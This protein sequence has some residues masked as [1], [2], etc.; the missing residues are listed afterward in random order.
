MSSAMS[1]EVVSEESSD[2]LDELRYQLLRISTSG[3]LGEDHAHLM[4][5]AL[6]AAAILDDFPEFFYIKDRRSRYVYVNAAT[7]TASGPYAATGMLGTTIFDHIRLEKAEE[8]FM[9]EQNLMSSGKGFLEREEFIEI[10]DRDPIWLLTTKTPLFNDAGEVIGLLGV[11]RDITERK[12]QEELRRCHATLLEMIARGQPLPNVLETL[13]RLVEQQLGDVC[14]SVLLMEEGTDRLRHGAAP[15]LPE[16]Y[17]KL[18]DGIEI[19]PRTGSCGTA[20]WRQSRVIVSDIEND[21][22]WHSFA[23]LALVFGFR[24][25]WS[26]PI[27]GPDG[28]VLGTVA[29]YARSVREPT[30]LELEVMS[31]ATDIAGIA[32]ERTR[33]EERIRHMAHHDALTG[34]PNRALFWTQFNRV[35]LE[36]K[37]E[38]RKVTVA[39][40]DLDNF[41]QINDRHGH[42]AGDEVLK[43]LAGRL[44]ACVRASD[45][46]VRLGGDEFAIV[47]PNSF[48]DEPHVVRRLQEVRIALSSPVLIEGKTI[49][50]SCSMGA[51]FYPQDGDNPE[52]LLASADRAMYDAKQ[53]GRD[54]LSITHPVLADGSGI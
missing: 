4:Q 18:I 19:G 27:M 35:L 26:M 45:L 24:A 50:P 41:K 11:S 28:A 21:P 34:L 5:R 42:A 51:A 44:A 30:P 22:L 31:V 6:D 39:Y 43:V 46:L 15:S 1:R 49:R 52:S 32:I 25:C 8:I 14:A 53:L 13:S 40:I 37:R 54:R 7:A 10:L 3:D 12:R 33:N 29:L 17:V 36:A 48:Q 16:T 23:D 9:L 2:A 38:R 47:F 20:A